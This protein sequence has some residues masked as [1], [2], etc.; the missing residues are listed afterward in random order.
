MKIGQWAQSC[1]NIFAAHVK[2]PQRTSTTEEALHSASMEAETGA[3]QPPAKDVWSPWK[4]EEE[5]IL[6]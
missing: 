2:V 1:V 6:P 5:R 3:T 4:L